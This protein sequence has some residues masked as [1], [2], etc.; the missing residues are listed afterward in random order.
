MKRRILSII[1][2]LALCLSLCP[3]WALAA[4]AD[5]SLCKHHPE[6]TEDCGYTAPTEGHDCGHRHT[7]ECYTKGV[8]PDA[9]GGDYYEIGADTEN[10]LD[11]QHSHDSECGYVEADPGAPCGYV[12]RICPI[13]DL[14]AALPEQVTEDNAADVRAQ[15]DRILDLYRE[16][17]EDEQEEINLS[18][19]YALQGALDAANDPDMIEGEVSVTYQEASWNGSEVTYTGKTEN[20][21]SVEGSTEAVTWNAGWY[22]VNSSVTISEPITVTGAVNL[23]LADG[24]TLNAQKGIVVETGNSLTIYAQSGSGTLNATGTTDSSNNASAG[25][26]GSTS[27]F[28]S[29]TITIHGGAINATGGSTDSIG[30]GGAGIGGGT[31]NYGNGGSSGAITIYGGTVTANS[32][33]GGLTGA[34]I[35]GGGGEEGGTSSNITIYGG[36]VTAASIDTSTGGAG[37]GGGS[38]FTR[39]GGDSNIQI[40]GGT[41]NATGGYMGAGIGGGAD[42]AGTS[43]NGTVTISGGTVTA[44][45]G[46][47]A[48]GIGGG[49]GYSAQYSSCTGGTGSVTISGGIVD[50]TGGAGNSSGNYAGDPIGN[51][52]NTTAAATV[53]KTTGIV[54]ENGAGT[55]CGA[56]TLDGSYTVP[57]DYTLNIPAGASLSGSGTLNG[58]SAFTTENLT[59]DMISVPTNLYYNGEDRTEYLTTELS[60]ALT[61]GV[62]ICGQTFTVSGWTL[63]VEKAADSDLTYTAT[64]TNNSD[65]TKTVQKTITLL[66]SGTDLTDGKVKTYKDGAE[67]SDFT[68]GDTIT[69]KATPTPTGDAPQKA[70]ARL[71]GEPGTGQ[72]ALY[73][74]DALVSSEA[75]NADTD[76][77]YTMTVS[78][79]DVL[80]AAG[81]PKTG[82]T[83][84][85]RFTA[86][87]N[88]ADGAGTATVNITAA[89]KAE[90]D[91]NVIDYF[92]VSDFEGTNNLFC[93]NDYANATITLLEDVQPGTNSDAGTT[94]SA[95][96]NITCTLDLAGHNFTSTDTAIYVLPMGNL[97]IQDSSTGKTGNVSFIK[98]DG[99]LT[100]YGGTFGK[101]ETAYTLSSLLAKNCAYYRGSTPI[102]LSELEGQKTLDGTVTVQECRH[103]DVTP[104]ANNDGTHTLRCPYCGYTKA[105]ENCDYGEYTHN[106]TSHT[107]ICKLCGYQNV[108]AHKIKCTAEAS[109][110]VIA[111]SEACKTCGYGKDLGTVTIH[112][113]KLVYGDLTGVVTA[114]NTLTEPVAVAGNVKNPLGETIIFS[115]HATIGPP[116]MATLTGNALLSAG[117]HKIRINIVIIRDENALAECELTFNVDPAP[118]TPSITG[119]ASKPYDGTTDVASGQL[120]ITLTGVVGSDNVTAAAT[121]YAY[122]NTNA[123]ENKTIT[124]SGI[125]LEG[126][127]KD[128][129]TL[130]STTATTTGTITK[131]QPTIVFASGYN[132]SKTYD[133]QTISNPTADDL[134]ITG[135]NFSDVTFEWSATP[136]DA[137]TY[138]LTAKIAETNN[139]EAAQTDPLTVTISK[140]TLTITGATVASKPYDGADTATVSGVTFTGL[141]NGETLA[142]GT[143]YTATGTFAD[144]NAGEDKSV[145]VTVTLT[146]DKAKNYNLAQNTTTATGTINRASSTITTAPTA[147]G[148]TY[149]EALRDST[150]TGGEGS[151]EGAF[152]WTA[153]ATKPNA[154]TAQYE[155]T[156]TPTDTN[157]DTATVNVTVTV[158]K[159]TPTLTAPTAGAIQYGQK[160]SDSALTGGTAT[161]PNGGAAVAGTWSWANGNTQPTATGAFPVAFVPSDTANYNTPGNV[162]ASVTVN[163]AEPKITL[164]VP[165]YQVAG[166]GVTVTCKVENP[167]DAAFTD[168]IPSAT[169]TYKIGDGAEQT[170][171]GTSFTIP[172]GTAK[173]TVITVTAST[174]AV[175]GK[176]TA[177]TKTAT[178]TVTDKIP[179]TITGVTAQGGTY[180]GSTHRGYSG[181]PTA[182]PYS[183]SFTAA[184]TGRNDTSYNSTTA[185]TNAGDYT[186]TISLA[187]TGTYIGSL[188]LDFTISKASITITAD[189]KRAD[190][191]AAKPALTYT[192]T[193]LVSGD[194]LAAAPTL[195]CDADMNTIG[196]YPITASGAA[197]PSGGNYNTAITYVAGTL[198]VTD[199]TIP[200]TGVTLNKASTT[201]T[202]GGSERLTAT[203]APSDATDKSVTWASSNT[204]VA[205]VDAN[206]TVT[207]VSAGKATIT[208]TT[209]DGAKTAT[210]TVT[211]RTNSSGGGSYVPSDPGSSTITVPVS[212]DK[213]TV[214]VSASVSGTT[215]TVSKIDTSQIENVIGDNGQA[216][217]V[218]ID[219]TGLGKTID[220]VKL[221]TAAVKDIA[222]KAQNEEVGGLT[223]KLPEAEISFD[224]NALSAIQAQ[225]GSQ[226]TLT[227]TPA[228]PADLNSRQK[229]AVGSAPVFDLTLRSSSGAITDFR[230]GY[231]TVSLPYTL[232]AGQNPSGVVVYY[233]DSTGNI[234]PCTTMYD[235]RSKSA[236][237]T[238]GHLSLYFVGYD[239][240]AVWVNPFS[241]VAEGAWYYDAVRYASENGLMGGYG[242][243]RFGPN[244]NLSRAQFAQILFNKEGRPVVNYLLRYNDVADGAWYTEAVRWATS[245]GVVSGYGNGMFGP[246]DN[247][248]RE[249]LAVMLWRYAGSPAATEKELHFTD[250]DKANGYAL[251]ALRWAVENGVMG[252]YGNGQLAPQGLA[253]RAQV[254]Q[255]LKN[256]IEFQQEVSS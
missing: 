95:M 180:N 206:G 39:G 239:P 148:I 144:A 67:C 172:E 114:E 235:V 224:T 77:S 160:L 177:A 92:G 35:G 192:V 70:A 21:T 6:H 249:Q 156:F 215:A 182:S 179:V 161:N 203:V 46:K 155:V 93:Q 55:V 40:H 45:G 137:G 236:I 91:G 241:D 36:S 110:T 33:E 139:T 107:R 127:S 211:V 255:M 8:L 162:D 113:P 184:Y 117:E 15:L 138:T 181:T 105:A 72:M 171:T 90:R 126:D 191:G 19:I 75:A 226:I 185:P 18:R 225:A 189:D 250:A 159:A 97:T 11:C 16:L 233:L 53:S 143:D 188:S 111:V 62:T 154:G 216:S 31:P 88:M 22:V 170:L 96:V 10:L 204:A 121:S 122:D 168:G 198:S 210:C 220:T 231:A 4:E 34:G 157:Y 26:G 78:A 14:I 9:D 254:A 237:F 109:G 232:T 5:P 248:T 59:E 106:D 130:S 252:G 194:T 229:E 65:N 17:N 71:R 32:G 163:P 151:V 132:P 167:Y 129:Y 218:E 256:F 124:A 136:K 7:A 147:T 61:K 196:Q 165:A 214:H 100:L 118:L 243:G 84:T 73:V 86:N 37:I 166:K 207:A 175:D 140:A 227:V 195:T 230:G 94:C 98:S 38:G 102:L 50:A 238:T 81:G 128:N 202:V 12:C 169:L 223:V 123:G 112:I 190:V 116:T 240:T 27:S 142:L 25:I 212:G 146:S 99:T 48:A 115:D 200:V 208:V 51:G 234:T 173:D 83:L 89:A 76:G 60:T 69:V 13:E 174:A 228:K 193:G 221:P 244:D 209:A 41:V 87:D 176:Y 80:L 222:A 44:I 133:G 158:A 197:V 242:N 247:I 24:C 251:E 186:V 125:T 119:T 149:G 108:E 66:Q 205:T 217:M 79:A 20:C 74:G 57:A 23:I 49:G 54:F 47:Y 103:K 183:G 150:L 101:I 245:Q 145:T 85:A 199:P 56:V 30:Y 246:N 1:T 135:A 120:S 104:T 63:A 201:L 64:Y 131:S 253:T 134:I 82:I 42:S 152:T 58:G 29:G 28:D 68:A 187:E 43:G 178:V 52:G 3:T 164:T 213:S 153:P 141:V 2:A 219:F